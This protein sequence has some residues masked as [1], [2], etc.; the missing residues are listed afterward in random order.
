MGWVFYI[1]ALCLPA[2]L[3]DTAELCNPVFNGLVFPE[4]SRRTVE[5]ALHWSKAQSKY[6]GA[7][8]C[9]KRGGKNR[10]LVQQYKF[11]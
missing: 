2:V 6:S 7:N 11:W 4:Y 10:V 5:H 1:L 8:F 9:F 3:G